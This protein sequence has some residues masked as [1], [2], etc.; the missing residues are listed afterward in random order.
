MDD[1]TMRVVASQA[2][3]GPLTS[4]IGIYRDRV[5]HR[6]SSIPKLIL[7]VTTVRRPLLEKLNNQK[8]MNFK[9]NLPKIK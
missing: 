3:H 4:R 9:N 7:L 1:I 5:I 8:L 6:T 2:V